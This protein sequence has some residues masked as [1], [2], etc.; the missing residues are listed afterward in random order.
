MTL[1]DA[2]LE[3]YARHIILREVGGTGQAKLLKSK[4]LV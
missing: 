3:R 2:Q 4:V 1:T